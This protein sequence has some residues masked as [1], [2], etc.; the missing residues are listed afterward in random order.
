[1][2]AD[3]YNHMCHWPTFTFTFFSWLPRRATPRH[4]SPCHARAM[5]LVMVLV[6]VLVI[7]LELA[8]CREADAF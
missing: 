2:M 4:A 3:I 8:V 5:L 6:L 7:R 1:M